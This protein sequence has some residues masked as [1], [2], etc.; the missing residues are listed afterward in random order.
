M[1]HHVISHEQTA[2]LTA[3]ADITDRRHLIGSSFGGGAD[4]LIG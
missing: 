1:L 2:E 4:P 3:A